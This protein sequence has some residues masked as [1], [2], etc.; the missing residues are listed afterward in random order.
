MRSI[1]ALLITTLSTT[2]AFA[3]QYQI[4][5]AHTHV[6]FRVPHLVVSKVEGRFNKFEGGFTFDEKTQKLDNVNV[7]IKADSIDTNQ[8][9]RD[10][11]L[12]TA[13]FFDVAKFP[14]IKF[15]GVKTIYEEG[16]PDKV[17][18]KLTIHGVTKDVA[19]EVDYK[20]AVTDQMGV[21]RVA[22]EA[23]LKIDRKDYGMTW[24]KSLDKG[25]MAVGDEIKIEILGEATIPAA[26][27]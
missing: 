10:K 22:F 21:R 5:P 13:D 4:D 7:T 25:G 12:R 26:K 15:K 20:G 14:D 6:E 19:L 27:K 23:E 17:E 3:A 16:K 18:G 8:P 11:H 2:A 9:D 1:L 24:N